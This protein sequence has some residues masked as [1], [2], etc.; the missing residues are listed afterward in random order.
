[1][2]C[3]QSII[4]MHEKTQENIFFSYYWMKK[5]DISNRNYKD[6]RINIQRN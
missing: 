4:T 5:P 2:N 3:I 6:D 1:M